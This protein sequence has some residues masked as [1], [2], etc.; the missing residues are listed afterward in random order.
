[1]SIFTA[2]AAIG[3]LLAAMAFVC[4]LVISPAL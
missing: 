2:S 3:A 4:F 1:M